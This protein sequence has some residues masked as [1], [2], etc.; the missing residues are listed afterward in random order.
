MYSITQKCAESI[1]FRKEFDSNGAANEHV[2]NAAKEWLNES[3]PI[4]I[5]FQDLLINVRQQV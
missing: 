5:L 4:K 3:V 1:T 2:Y